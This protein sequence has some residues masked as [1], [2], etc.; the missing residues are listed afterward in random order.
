M[1]RKFRLIFP[2]IAACLSLTG[3]DFISI[4]DNT[5]DDT[6]VEG[7]YSKYNLNLSGSRLEQELQKMCFDKHTKWIKYG[8]LASYYKKNSERNGTDSISDGSSKIQWFYTGKETTDKGTREHVWPCA[9]S[10]DLWYRDSAVIQHQVERTSYIGGGADLYHVRPCDGDVNSIRGNSKYIDYDDFPDLTG[11]KEKGDGGPY[12]LKYNGTSINDKTG[13]EEFADKSEPAD[14][15]KG[16]VARI[17]MY[18]YIHYKE[19]GITPEGGVKSGSYTYN[20]THMTGGLK[21]TSILGYDSEAKVQKKLKEWNDLDPVSEVEKLRNE[22][23]Q[24]L[25]GNRNPFV[26]YPNLVGKVFN[27]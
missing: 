5:E 19:R 7:Y 17:I 3:C 6:T 11:V 27:L 8:D 2:I 10:S 22:T 12:T 24:K 13:K 26:D 25:Q 14:A 18:V 9:N 20:Y 4:S 15:M 21:L 1:K 23:V 16:D